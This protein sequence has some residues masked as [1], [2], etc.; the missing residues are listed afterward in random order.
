MFTEIYFICTG[1]II[2]LL[3]E[4]LNNYWNILKDELEEA[5]NTEK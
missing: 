4:S 5:Q 3:K 2:V 1:N